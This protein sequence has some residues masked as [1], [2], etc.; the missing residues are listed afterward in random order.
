MGMGMVWAIWIFAFFRFGLVWFGVSTYEGVLWIYKQAW[1]NLM[2]FSGIGL[3]VY[4][5]VWRLEGAAWIACIAS[6]H[7][8]ATHSFIVFCAVSVWFGVYGYGGAALMN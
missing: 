1:Y 3:Y 6:Q 5:Q 4:K 2:V 7:S 8:L